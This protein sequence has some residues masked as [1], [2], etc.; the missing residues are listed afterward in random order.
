MDAS[1]N[2]CTVTEQSADSREIYQTMTA[3]YDV[4]CMNR[5][6]FY[7]WVGKFKQGQKSIL[8]EP[9]SG[10]KSK[11]LEKFSRETLKRPFWIIAESQ[12]KKLRISTVSVLKQSIKHNS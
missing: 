7:S 6:S 2:D 4:S 12:W 10:R 11:C 5:A 8:N 1:L 3:Q 9:R